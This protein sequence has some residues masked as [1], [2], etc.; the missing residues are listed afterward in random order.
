MEVTVLTQTSQRHAKN[1][2]EKCMV[3]QASQYGKTVDVIVEGGHGSRTFAI[4]LNGERTTASTN[5]PKAIGEALL[6]L[7]QN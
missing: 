2:T 3:F 1:F 5:Y 6:I 7:N 4:F